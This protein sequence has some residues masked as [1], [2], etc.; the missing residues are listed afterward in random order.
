[1][2]EK[3]VTS[4]NWRRY[5]LKNCTNT[6]FNNQIPL[7]AMQYW[8]TRVF[9]EACRLPRLSDC[10]IVEGLQSWKP[11]DFRVFILQKILAIRYLYDLFHCSNY[12]NIWL[13]R[14]LGYFVNAKRREREGG[15]GLGGSVAMGCGDILLLPVMKPGGESNR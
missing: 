5:Y 10:V 11:Q 14:I 8:L 3:S 6:V 2:S 1:M 13:Y 7:H 9:I 15:L 12:M 4:K